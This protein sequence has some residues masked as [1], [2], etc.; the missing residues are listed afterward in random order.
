MNSILFSLTSVTDFIEKC[1]VSSQKIAHSLADIGKIELPNQMESWKRVKIYFFYNQSLE[2][3]RNRVN[4]ITECIE[5]E[6]LKYD[7][8]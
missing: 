1:N 5:K 3:F 4:F 8:N 6:S 2:Y 7:S